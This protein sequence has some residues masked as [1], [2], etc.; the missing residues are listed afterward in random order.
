MPLFLV[1][2]ME[3]EQMYRMLGR[4]RALFGVLVAV[5]LLMA[6][7]GS[8]DDTDGAE[9]PQ[10]APEYDPDGVLRVGT[11][12][13]R[14]GGFGF[15]PTRMGIGLYVDA[16]PVLA[17]LLTRGAGGDFQPYL[18]KEATIADPRTI[19]VV[20]RPDLEFSDG[21]P[22]NAAAVKATFDR[23]LAS[24][25]TNGLAIVDMRNVETIQE[26]SPTEF[27]IRLK[28]PSAAVVYG[29][30]AGI[31]FA[32]MAPSSFTSGAD[33]HQKP[34]GAGPMMVTE[35]TP[36]SRIVMKKNP[37]YWDAEN[38]LL[39]GMEYVHVTAEAATNAMLANQV[40]W[41]RLSNVEQVRGLSGSYV[42]DIAPTTAP[43][44]IGLCATQAPLNDLR[45]RQAIAYAVDRDQ[46]NDVIWAGQSEPA[47]DL[48]PSGSPFHNEDLD[49]NY[50]KD[51]TK[52]RSLLS[53]AGYPNGLSFTMYARAPEQRIAEL[54][55]GQLKQAGIDMKIV[56]GTDL[57]GDYFQN[58]RTN[59]AWIGQNRPGI[60]KVSRFYL[61][62]SFANAC[63]F[64]M[65]KVDALNAQLIGLELESPEA[66][67]I[68]E[69]LQEVIFEEYLP[70][71]Q[72][73]FHSDM[74]GYNADR[75]GELVSY[76]DQLGGRA[77]HPVGT[78]IAAS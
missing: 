45:V 10:E 23:N 11:D 12:L 36:G 30:L 16:T 64:P 56:I 17:P 19:E 21:S 38:V 74:H 24:N 37:N 39:G 70:Y 43:S 5:S 8:D 9:S 51:L 48:W 3:G 28:T 7:C 20:L 31:E 63:K 1:P 66:I 41:V 52:A 40:D 62:N 47:W 50:E 14:N 25:N 2:T 32:P 15:D 59:S 78:Y 27:T 77:P 60:D 55:Q 4:T 53:E 71:I 42:G 65:P 18:A 67:A 54:L 49:G 61:S 72:L 13:V 73:V 22:V 33:I 34:V 46:F 57:A 68:W 26:T 69:E 29:L 76:Y 6:S 75:V 44:Q 35:F 58:A